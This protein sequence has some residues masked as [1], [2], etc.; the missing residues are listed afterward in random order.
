M[1]AFT[2]HCLEGLEP[3]NLLAWL[4][5]LGLLRSLEVMK[6]E[7]RPRAYWAGEPIR[8][9][10]RVLGDVSQ[11]DVCA[12]SSAGCAELAA[13]HDFG[14]TADLTFPQERARRMLEEAAK[15]ETPNFSALLDALF[16]DGAVKDDGTIIATPLCAMFGQG[17]QH[18]LNRLSSVPKGELPKALMK[19]KNAPDLNAPER[20]AEALFRPWTREDDT[21]GF[22][23][24]PEENRRYA[25]RFKNPSTDAGT[26]Q[27]GA[28]RLAAVGLPVL[29]GAAVKRRGRMR[30]LILG[31]EYDE[32][33]Q[34]RISWPIWERAASLTGIRSWAAH[35]AL[36]SM[37][38]NAGVW[39]EL[40]RLGVVGVYRSE[41]LTI[42]KYFNF[43]VG[44]KVNSALS[45]VLSLIVE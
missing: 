8:P 37:G 1:T 22:R 15:P 43:S 6:P 18:F 34:I 39:S 28:N 30:F 7:W 23:W 11:E 31:A 24:D 16:S 29:T 26:T 32:E 12:A 2:E 21:D 36:V 9:M 14:G 35:P 19:R 41:R 17:H 27:H 45:T 38:E 44:V 40:G 5:L 13:V 42:G 25:L 3:D 10:L 33:G 20:L 4:A